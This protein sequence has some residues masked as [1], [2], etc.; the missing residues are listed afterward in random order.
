MDERNVCDVVL[1]SRVRLA[2]NLADIPFPA[3]M[4]GEDGA[5]AQ[6]RILDAVKS[7]PQGQA[8]RFIRV[9]DMEDEERRILVE[10]NLISRELL[11]A[12]PHAAAMLRQDEAAALLV[13]EDDHLRI[14]ALLSGLALEEAA[15]VAFEMDEALGAE[16]KFAYDAELGYLTSLLSNTGTGM[17]A[18]AALHLP[19]LL[20]TGAV[21]S[22]MQEMAK[23]GLFLKPLLGENKESQGE[24][25]LAGN[26][27]A[28]GRTEEELID[29]LGAMLLQVVA[30]ERAAREMLLMG[31][32]IRM[33]DRL[34]RSLG[35]LRYA[36]RLT[37]AEWMRKWSDVRLAVLAGMVPIDLKT[38]DE[39]LDAVKPAH[40]EVAAGTDLST[41]ER[42]ERRAALVREAL[43]A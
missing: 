20:R 5:I 12:G 28:L 1:K 4:H 37:Y 13:N 18:T 30:R 40:L 17:R 15:A 29:T 41:T 25:F 32:D 26:Q 42:D 38:L 9:H 10:R 21:A 11:S 43:G 3:A 6:L 14:S 39:L 34:M 33:E 19:G 24:L 36:R 2:R 35:I 16:L 8:Y 27:L 31:S 23:L 7:T 22:L